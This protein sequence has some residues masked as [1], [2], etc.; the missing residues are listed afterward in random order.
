MIQNKKIKM[1]N[2]ENRLM[3]HR[4]CPVFKNYILFLKNKKNKKN[5]NDKFDSFFCLLET[6][7]I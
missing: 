1:K 6:R 3:N 4:A 7:R 5:M 2:T